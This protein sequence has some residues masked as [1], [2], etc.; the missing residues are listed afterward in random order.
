MYECH[1]ELKRDFDALEDAAYEDMLNFSSE[2]EFDERFDDK[3]K[4]QELERV[5]D[6]SKPEG[7]RPS[8]AEVKKNNRKKLFS[9]Y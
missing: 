4:A 1:N 6:R 2:I 9:E 7:F 3:E 8:V 5:I